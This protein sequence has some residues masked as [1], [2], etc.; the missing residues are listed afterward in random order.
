M[1]KF[2]GLVYVKHGRV[3]SKS[4]GPDY[5]LQTYFTEYLLRDQERLPWQP[6]YRLE[7]FVRRMVEVD[8]T[9]D[10]PTTIQVGRITELL[11]AV[12]PHPDD[13]EMNL[14]APFDLGCGR[15]VRVSDEP[16]ELA[17]VAVVEESRSP[18]GAQGTAAGQCILACRLTPGGGDGVAF[19][20]TVC[21]GKPELAATKVLGYHV[22]LHDITPCPTQDEPQPS[23]D[24]YTARLEINRME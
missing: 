13:E 17:F 6:D 4:E 18:A 23:H 22:A 5:F 7:F 2:R 1:S 8:G 20:L 11:S 10:D 14:G 24:R 3:G 15:R 12:L 16:I 21:A 9:L 19:T